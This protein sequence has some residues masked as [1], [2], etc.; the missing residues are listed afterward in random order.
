[1]LDATA[2]LVWESQWEDRELE[3]RVLRDL[4]HALR[5]NVLVRLGGRRP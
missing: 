4:S 3:V 1:M 5:L 2:N